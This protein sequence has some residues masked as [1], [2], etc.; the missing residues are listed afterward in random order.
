MYFFHIY[1]LG[2]FVFYCFIIILYI[3]HSRRPVCKGYGEQYP[4]YRC[5]QIVLQQSQNFDVKDCG[6]TESDGAIRINSEEDECLRKSLNDRG[7][8]VRGRSDSHKL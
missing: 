4:T 1:Y 7:V 6:I 2:L 8:L 3:V 5:Y